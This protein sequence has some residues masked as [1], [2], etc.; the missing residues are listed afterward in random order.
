[1]LGSAAVRTLDEV[2]DEN[3]DWFYR[4]SCGGDPR[5]CGHWD[6]ANDCS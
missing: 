3:L 6:Q 2:Q 5:N 4:C 1:M